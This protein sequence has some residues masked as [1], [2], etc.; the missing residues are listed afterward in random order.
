L[1]P[2]PLPS[3]I[4]NKR[5]IDEHNNNHVLD[6]SDDDHA[7]VLSLGVEEVIH[8]NN[9]GMQYIDIDGINMQL[10]ED[11]H[12]DTILLMISSIQS[13]AA[14]IEEKA[15]KNYTRRNLKNLPNWE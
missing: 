12:K 7:Q 5:S 15:I 3:S 11:I 10:N 4:E 9:I 2:E 8:I 14:T 1:A 6:E 13:P